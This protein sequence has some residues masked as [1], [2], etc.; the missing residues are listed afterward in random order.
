MLKTELLPPQYE[1]DR[2]W[3]EAWFLAESML[4]TDIEALHRLMPEVNNVIIQVMDI[5]SGTYE[6]IFRSQ[7]AISRR[8]FNKHEYTASSSA[9]VR[10]Y[11]QLS[12]EQA[13][14]VYQRVEHKAAI[15]GSYMHQLAGIHTL[16][17]TEAIIYQAAEVD[18][19]W[20]LLY[21][22]E[23][24]EEFTGLPVRS[25]LGGSAE[26][27]V[28]DFIHPDDLNSVFTAYGFTRST[29][30]SVVLS[31]RLRDKNGVYKRV[32]EQ[33]KY[34]ELDGRY[35]SVSLIWE[36]DG[37]K[38]QNDQVVDIFKKLEDFT[39]DVSLQ[40][41][42][43][44]LKHFGLR[45]GQ[46]SGVNR[47]L[48]GS[49]TKPKWWRTWLIADNVI[50]EPNFHFLLNSEE[51]LM[52]CSWN[53]TPTRKEEFYQILYSDYRYYS[54]LPIVDNAETET[55]F[56][57]LCTN[58]PIENRAYISN[59]I[60]LFGVRVLREI[61]QCEAKDRLDEQNSLL[62]RQKHQLTQLVTLL[63]ELD[64]VSDEA[65]FLYGCQKS[66]SDAFELSG[67]KW[68]FWESGDWFEC[69]PLNEPHQHWH[70]GAQLVQD[71]QQILQLDECRRTDQLVKL[72]QQ[73]CIHW[74]I[75]L[76]HVGFLVLELKFT[77]AMPDAE[78]LQ[79]SK[80]AVH[81]AMQGLTQREVLRTQAMRDS[82]TNLGN[83][84]QLHAW[85][86]AILPSQRKSALMLFDLNRFKEINDSFGHQFGDKLLRE[87][88]P[89]INQNLRG[90]F[91]FLSRL[92]GD[93]FALFYPN[94]SPKD[95]TEKARMLHDALAEPYL[96]DQL[97]FQVEASVGVS[98]YPQHG[99]DGHELLRCADVAMYS[100]KNTGRQVTSYS[101]D[102]D[103]STP[104]KIA[105]LS[106]LDSALASGQLFVVYQP[107]MDTN[108]GQTGGLEAL[109]RWTH[110]DFGFLS[111]ADFIP[112]SEMGEG[113]RKI[114]DFVIRDAFSHINEWREIIPDLQVSVNISPR[115]LLNQNFPS[116][117][118]ELLEEYGVSGKSVIM[119]LTESTLLVDPTRAI[120]IIKSLA[121]LGIEVEIDDFGTGYSSLSYLKQL[122]ISA[123][124]IDRS[125]VADLLSDA[126]DEV[127]VSSTIKMAHSLGLKT[128]AEGVEDEVTLVRLMRLGCDII[129]GYYYAKPMPVNEVMG[130]LDRNR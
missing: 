53:A 73:R 7:P 12:S 92:G 116:Y 124:K 99:S 30:Q 85:M 21:A 110:P 19:R 41:G 72:K 6:T 70:K 5:Y 11:G 115:V 80:N 22:N 63:G 86:K 106:E 35:Q 9:Q 26:F 123:L 95:A 57:M 126:S 29:M 24:L 18:G 13:E 112:I 58:E 93:E 59:L 103:T 107:L 67:L 111:P 60:E 113:I 4:R 28:S 66:F 39:Q 2:G 98:F 104:H 51:Q 109:V 56:V 101:A 122:P 3:S 130:W 90:E 34:Q 94:I 69:S 33:V 15:I 87:I 129:Q 45:I 76:S 16:A 1:I 36:S 88:G 117:I 38:E 97:T 17:V 120:E 65:E 81:L 68:Y 52:T 43:E 78:I 44:F 54:V 23:S 82:L 55:A 61:A 48:L 119:E 74:P 108:T 84:S 114:T 14:S 102:L 121:L 125:F 100:S 25:F 20:I 50:K 127:I 77:N 83:R 128:V 47:I 32:S 89:R 75:G 62:N 10:I 37:D 46:L 31:Y 96:V 8:G 118:E 40:T 79:F 91:Y 64:T 27:K 49:Q 71:S 42:A 105:V